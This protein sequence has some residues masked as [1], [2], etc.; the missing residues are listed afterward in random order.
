VHL[1]IR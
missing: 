1:Y